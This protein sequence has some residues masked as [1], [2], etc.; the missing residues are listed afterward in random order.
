MLYSK[1]GS[2]ESGVGSR[3]FPYSLERGDLLPTPER[4]AITE[5]WTGRKISAALAAPV[6]LAL[7]LALA[8]CG[9]AGDV[10]EE[11]EVAAIPPASAGPA[12][13]LGLG[14]GVRPLSFGP[15][16]KG[17]PRVSPSGESVA[18]V[19]DGY[20]TEKPLY[21]Q[22]FHR[23][24][25]SDSGA[26]HAEWLPDGSLAVLTPEEETGEDPGAT[27]VPNS[28][29]TGE[30][31]GAT[32][33]PNSIFAVQP[34]DSSNARRLA[35][36]VMATSAVPGGGDVVVAVSTPPTAEASGEAMGSRL[37]LLRGS[38]EQLKL[39]LQ[40]TQGRVTGLS[41]SP[42]GSEAALAVRRDTGEK[43]AGRF[44]VQTY[45]FPEGQVES[46]ARVPEG[47]EILGAPQWTQG[48]I[49]F[50]AGESG[51]ASRGEDPASYALYRVP[52]GSSEPEPVRGVG[53]DFVAAGI[54]AS[55]D[56]A[57]L[58]VVGR[59]NPGSPTNLYILDLA[60]DAL[61]AATTNENMEIKTSPRDLTWSP[62]GRSVVLV[63]RGALSGPEVYDAPAQTL[64][65]AFYN[66][67][68]VPAGGS[69]A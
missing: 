60:S 30:D 14:T 32:P 36:R 18:F 6:L 22:S 64:S 7:V 23:K 56:G 15:G 3:I 16:D 34:D 17:S 52:S 43:E 58:A 29:E 54:S 28:D 55:P 27:P 48:G 5:E 31:P 61:E 59:R 10:Q 65:S 39:Y 4:E 24:I 9:L 35:R 41:I 38:E 45:R 21:A 68:E 53:E 26:E 49:Y 57:R 50:V 40:G 25:A 2:R 37:V 67:Y 13:D 69:G 42:D 66:L 47:M 46:A 1:T 19:L 8:G 62:D 51:E 63:A 33:V 12:T 20:V 44:E 11:E